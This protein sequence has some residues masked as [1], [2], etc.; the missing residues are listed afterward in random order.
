MRKRIISYNFKFLI[1][2]KNGWKL[3]VFIVKIN[4]NNLFKLFVKVKFKIFNKGIKFKEAVKFKKSEIKEILAVFFCF[5]F[6]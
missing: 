2:F 1:I 4:K 3:N 6:V 5:N